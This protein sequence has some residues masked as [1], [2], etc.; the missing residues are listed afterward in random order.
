MLNAI[1]SK[2]PIYSNIQYKGGG[3]EI[4]ITCLGGGQIV[5]MWAYPMADCYHIVSEEDYFIEELM[6]C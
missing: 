4:V 2:M 1:Y 3:G 5:I 6:Q